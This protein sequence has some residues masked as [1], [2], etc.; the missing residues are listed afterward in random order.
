MLNRFNNLDV[1]LFSYR[2]VF[3]LVLFITVQLLCFVNII[4]AQGQN[5][6]LVRQIGGKFNTVAVDGKY[7]YI[8]EGEEVVTEPML[9]FSGH[10]GWV[11]SVAFSYD[12][13]MVVSSDDDGKVIV[14]DSTTGNKI[15]TIILNSWWPHVAFSRDGKQILTAGEGEH[16]A[17]IWDITTGQVIYTFPSYVDA[18]V[19]CA[20]F[21]PNEDRILMGCYFTARLWNIKTYQYLQF[22]STWPISN[23]DVHCVAFSP[24]GAKILTGI[25]GGPEGIVADL[26]DAESGECLYSFS[27]HTSPIYTVCYSPD[28][29][30]I[31]TASSG[32]IKI[33]DGLLKNEIKTLGG[34]GGGDVVISP[35][36]Q[37]LLIPTNDGAIIYNMK[38]NNIDVRFS[39]HDKYKSVTSVAFSSDGCQILTG[40]TD[41]TVKIWNIPIKG[42]NL[43]FLTPTNNNNFLAGENIIITIRATK[44]GSPIPNAH[45]TV[46]LSIG[47]RTCTY[48]GFHD[49]GIDGDEK[50]GDGIYSKSIALPVIT[51]SYT[52]SAHATYQEG[53]QAKTLDATPINITIG[54]ATAALRISGKVGDGSGQPVNINTL[55]N[56]EGNVSVSSGQL[57]AGITA[58]VTVTKPDKTQTNISLTSTNNT[59]FT[60]QVQLDQAGEYEFLFQPIPPAGSGL[61][62]GNQSKK[63]RVVIG[64]LSI[65]II[66]PESHSYI[67]VIKIDLDCTVMP[68][69]LG[70]IV[71][72]YRGDD[73]IASLFGPVSTPN[74]SNR[75]HFTGVYSNIAGGPVTLRFV[76]EHPYY[77]SA[78]KSIDFTINSIFYETLSEYLKRIESPPL[79]IPSP[80]EPF[81]GR[82]YPDLSTVRQQLDYVSDEMDLLVAG[83]DWLEAEI[84]DSFID[85][86]KETIFLGF[87]IGYNAEPPHQ[88][89]IKFQ[90]P[91]I[92]WPAN[93]AAEE[94]YQ[95]AT[96]IYRNGALGRDVAHFI[97][98]GEVTRLLKWYIAGP[99]ATKGY[100]TAI[101]KG[102]SMGVD[103]AVPAIKEVFKWD[104][105]T[106]AFAQSLWDRDCPSVY[107]PM[108]N[109]VSEVR[110]ELGNHYIKNEPQ[111]IEHLKS[112]MAANDVRLNWMFEDLYAFHRRLYEKQHSSIGLW[113]IAGI[114]LTISAIAFPA[115]APIAIVCDLYSTGCIMND[116]LNIAE[117]QRLKAFAVNSL[118][119]VVQN[120]QLI[121]H[122][123]LAGLSEVQAAIVNPDHSPL[124]HPGL[125]IEYEGGY[126]RHEKQIE[127]EYSSQ[128]LWVV[129]MLYA[130]IRVTNTGNEGDFIARA[131]WFDPKSGGAFYSTK[132]FTAEGNAGNEYFHLNTNETKNVIVYFYFKPFKYGSWDFNPIGKMVNYT[133]LTTDPS[134]QNVYAGGISKMFVDVIEWFPGRNESTAI[135]KDR[136]I[137]SEEDVAD[138]IENP[139]CATADKIPSCRNFKGRIIVKNPFSFPITYTLQQPTSTTITLNSIDTTTSSSTEGLFWN[140]GLSANET[141]SHEFQFSTNV[142]IGEAF[143]LPKTQLEIHNPLGSGLKFEAEYPTL[144][145]PSKTLAYVNFPNGYD[146]QKM[147][148]LNF[149]LQNLTSDTVNMTCRSIVENTSG[150]LVESSVHNLSL[151][152]SEATTLTVSLDLSLNVDYYVVRAIVEEDGREILREAETVVNREITIKDLVDYLLGRQSLQLGQ[153]EAANMNGD[154]RIDI[155]DL[156]T[157]I[158]KGNLVNK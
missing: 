43:S 102:I 14:W 94:F 122:N 36:S 34:L 151:G 139:I 141:I 78:E 103:I 115:T 136:R 59:L 149:H 138:S 79:S 106:L 69:Q 80:Y 23:R 49:D 111:I 84:T 110:Q 45:I 19:L 132:L 47:T 6:E 63:V 50:A 92:E 85:A 46:N 7:D 42:D 127:I 140:I 104:G 60:G 40:S 83:A 156:I 88:R 118:G 133:F 143:N 134:G 57:P 8:G 75:I 129:S 9:T 153:W 123:L 154:D 95:E 135:H 76:A 54:K 137:L 146:S 119:I 96:N 21:S 114:A 39:G 71:R 65:N 62:A 81:D 77:R 29:S 13:K 5:V 52:L 74:D 48:T 10:Y 99:V 155:A 35:D 3:L 12:G 98:T 117:D 131:S 87:Q 100:E 82:A 108:R 113:E 11:T 61:I 97:N 22:Y 37:K 32:E 124:P 91:V 147:P 4:L 38:T 26:W 30:I 89:T 72:V 53:D 33:W 51:G 158:K 17:K 55:V 112:V 56:L 15:I 125:K 24:D 31:V 68:T 130:S 157:L 1:K 126:I 70:T 2:K 105:G 101:K 90:V 121:C 150:T 20:C 41:K 27:G 25:S 144:Y 16:A 73:Q 109:K 128:P 120:T 58:S 28:Q 148:F 64:D 67:N 66:S 142:P 86:V 18:S 116:L 152:E 93:N 44:D 145:A 107:N